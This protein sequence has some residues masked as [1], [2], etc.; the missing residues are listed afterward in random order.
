MNRM[1]MMASMG[2]PG[3]MNS[4]RGMGPGGMSPGMGPGGPNPGLRKDFTFLLA[5]IDEFM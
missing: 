2:G 5:I 1:P 3:A 4:I